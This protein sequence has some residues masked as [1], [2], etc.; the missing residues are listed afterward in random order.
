MTTHWQIIR[1]YTN[2][3]EHFITLAIIQ[4]PPILSHISIYGNTYLFPPILI[5]KYFIPHPLN[6]VQIITFK[7]TSSAQISLL[8]SRYIQPSAGLTDLL[9][10]LMGL[11]YSTWPKPWSSSSFPP[12]VFFHAVKWLTNQYLFRLKVCHS[13]FIFLFT[14]YFSFNSSARS[15]NILTTQ[16]LLTAFTFNLFKNVSLFSHFTSLQATSRESRLG[17]SFLID[18]HVCIIY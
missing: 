10:Y 11:S 17:G 2:S 14:L 13:S 8:I 4:S 3:R 7:F 1:C 18:C 5:V 12:T 16:W 15:Q 6:K 9:V